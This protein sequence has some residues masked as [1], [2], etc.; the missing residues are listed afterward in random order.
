[1]KLILYNTFRKYTLLKTGLIKL[2]INNCYGN[3][4]LPNGGLIKLRV[5]NFYGRHTLSN[6]GLT[7]VALKQDLREMYTAKDRLDK[8]EAPADSIF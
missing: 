7:S 6:R 3:C 5:K 1:M 2:R 8:V 4:T